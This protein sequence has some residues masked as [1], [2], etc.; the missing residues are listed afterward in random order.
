MQ[1]IDLDH[2]GHD[3]EDFHEQTRSPRDLYL[4]GG[5]FSI[6]AIALF[7]RLWQLDQIPF[8]VFDEVF[9]PKYAE[10]YLAGSPT[11]EGHPP[12]AKYL[13]MLGIILF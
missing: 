6:F 3:L 9:F 10:E 5:S 4:M 11:W 7:L 12:L 13:I 2:N 8:P 1:K